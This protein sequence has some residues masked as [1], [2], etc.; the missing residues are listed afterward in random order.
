[1]PSRNTK[2]NKASVG[3]D[4]YHY[5]HPDIEQHALAL[6]K[7]LRRSSKIVITPLNMM[8]V[9]H[10]IQQAR[11]LSFF[12]PPEADVDGLLTNFLEELDSQ[13]DSEED[14]GFEFNITDRDFLEII[15]RMPGPDSQ[16]RF[17]QL[18]RLMHKNPQDGAQ[19]CD[20]FLD[21]A[22]RGG[23]ADITS[24]L[25]EY[26]IGYISERPFDIA[27]KRNKALRGFNHNVFGE[28]LVGIK[29]REEYRK[30]PE[31]F[32][33]EV[34]DG[35]R[36]RTLQRGFPSFLYP[37]NKR[38]NSSRADDGLGQGEVFIQCCAHILTGPSTVSGT[39][40]L[41]VTSSR[42]TIYGIT[43][44]SSSIAAMMMLQT[45]VACSSMPNWSLR[46]GPFPLTTLYKEFIMV[47]EGSD[48]QKILDSITRS[49]PQLGKK[50]KGK[51]GYISSDDEDCG[52]AAAEILA[53]RHCTGSISSQRN[54]PEA[55]VTKPPSRGTQPTP[56]NPTNAAVQSSL[57]KH[58]VQ[59]VDGKG[60]DKGKHVDE[61]MDASQ[62][63]RSTRDLL[64][65]RSN[66]DVELHIGEF[67]YHDDPFSTPNDFME[68]NDDN[69]EYN[70][71]NDSSEDEAPPRKKV[72][73]QVFHSDAET[74]DAPVGHAPQTPVRASGGRRLPLSPLEN[75]H[76]LE[77]VARITASRKL[78]KVP[79][80]ETQL[81]LSPPHS[82][83]PPPSKVSSKKLAKTYKKRQNSH[84]KNAEAG[85]S[86]VPVRRSR[87][88]V[89][90]ME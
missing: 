64:M 79:I 57:H 83:P 87:R 67:Q 75:T 80:P 13:E 22:Y 40:R 54:S 18:L 86:N 23:R 30:D 20:K 70:D 25:K 69:N 6:L 28:A 19:L 76:S 81:L 84:V 27:D 58:R 78:Q 17:P 24:D 82:S 4:P 50:S 29:D 41:G 77:D 45:Y 8:G 51:N 61:Y 73:R 9:C 5:L 16:N 46:D 14:D 38:Y 37:R 47:L 2:K 68:E 36:K 21:R 55:A 66:I 11:G 43:S 33:S 34:N 56:V 89:G 72:R 52:G 60:K 1:M 53:Q 35:I 74:E 90:Q 71:D 31:I 49:L 10:Y 15:R 85:P 48:G 12:L 62:H 42:S 7:S 88:I 39:E 26:I 32:R 65:T 63:G 59:H 44:I 3:S